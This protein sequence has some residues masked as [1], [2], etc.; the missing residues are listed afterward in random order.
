MVHQ[1]RATIDGDTTNA[2]ATVWCRAFE[3]KDETAAGAEAGGTAAFDAVII[4]NC[5]LPA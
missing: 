5:W 4:G 3:I 1:N 2:A